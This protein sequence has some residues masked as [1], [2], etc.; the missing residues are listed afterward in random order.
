[1]ILVINYIVQV[2]A[3]HF[4]FFFVTKRRNRKS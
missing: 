2:L 4:I 3:V 1:M